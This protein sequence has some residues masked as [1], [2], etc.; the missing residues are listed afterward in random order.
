[1]ANQKT[2]QMM[3][4][5]A[6]QS[7]NALQSLGDAVF[8]HKMKNVKKGSREE[9]AFARKQFKFNKA[10]QLSLAF[11]DG[12][13]AI[14]ASLAASPVAIGPIPNPAGIASL[15]FAAITSA[16]QIATIA[17]QQFSGGA[18]WWWIWRWWWYSWWWWSTSDLELLLIHQR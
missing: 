2:I 18:A 3:L 17:A 4:E 8:A 1:M 9:E 11:I 16:A 12:A 13:K 15:A 7:A 10:L 14:N 5:L 6:T